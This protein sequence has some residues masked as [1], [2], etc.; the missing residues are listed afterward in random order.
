MLAAKIGFVGAGRM[1]TALAR[2]FVATRL[3]DAASLVASD[4]SGDARERF[5]EAVPGAAV[6]G[7]NGRV[8]SSRN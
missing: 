7:D 3:L 8:P 1:A 5:A 2:G 4:P 6:G